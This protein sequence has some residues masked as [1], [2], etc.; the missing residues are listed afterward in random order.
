MA[1]KDTP[2]KKNGIL[3]N[4]IVRNL[5]LAALLIAV[6]LILTQVGLGLVTRHNRTVTVPDFTN[7]TVAEAH[8]AA[9]EAH[10]GVK[11]TD[12][13]FIRRL[14]A[15]VIYRQ[16]PKA[17]ATVK[18]GRSIF[19]TINSIVP[20]KVVMP[21]LVGYSLNEAR[22]ELNNRGLSLGKLHYTQ[23]IATN[24]VLRQSV[25][26]RTVRAGDLVIS[27][28]DVDLTLG[29]SSDAGTT[30]VPKV[31]GMKYIRAV[32]ALHDRYLNVGRVRFDSDIRT[33]ADSVNAVVYRQ[34]GIGTARPYGT[35][36]NIYLTL[37]PEKIPAE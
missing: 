21:N 31:V 37:D 33:Y 16:A 12:S 7:M 32:D 2:E 24:N 9:R 14:G 29:L 8:D 26:G 6:L 36:I 11:V 1:K 23:D 5:L 27:G 13:V 19:L 28:S 20:R 34:D 35:G 15:G 3:S 10:V 17:G 22:A 4:W 30:R 25:R 18:K